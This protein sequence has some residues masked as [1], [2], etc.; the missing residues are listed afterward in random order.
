MSPQIAS[1][2][3]DLLE[4]LVPRPVFFVL[5]ILVKRQ[6]LVVATFQKVPIDEV[7]EGGL[8]FGDQERVANGGGAP[9]KG[10]V[11]IQVQ[12]YVLVFTQ[13]IVIVPGQ[14]DLGDELVV[15]ALCL[16]CGR[17]GESVRV[18]HVLGSQSLQLGLEFGVG[19]AQ[20]AILQ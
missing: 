17:G 10:R 19:E 12:G 20:L 13:G 11:R 1:G 18:F 7:R 16:P 4:S 2:L 5:V 3:L 8:L 15:V 6:N 9:R 14:L